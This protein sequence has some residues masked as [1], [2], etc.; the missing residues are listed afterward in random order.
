MTITSRRW[1]RPPRR[2]PEWC[3][4]DHQ[5]TARHGYPSGEHRSDPLR[6]R[7]AY[8]TLVATRIETIQGEGRMEVRA[9]AKLPADQGLARRQAQQL[10]VQI[11]LAIRDVLRL[12]PLPETSARPALQRRSAP[13]LLTRAEMTHRG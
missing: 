2:C 8:G 9:V 13:E 10:A 1:R 4:R 5:C 3:A 6:W 11:D 7:T 12:L